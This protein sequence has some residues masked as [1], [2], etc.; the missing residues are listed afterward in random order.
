MH[1]VTCRVVSRG[2]PGENVPVVKH[3]SHAPQHEQFRCIQKGSIPFR[4][5]VSSNVPSNVQD[6]LVYGSSGLVRK[7]E[8]ALFPGVSSSSGTKS[9]RILYPCCCGIDPPSPFCIL[10][11]GVLH[12]YE[13]A[14]P[15][16][17]LNAKRAS[18]PLSRC[19]SSNS[20]DAQNKR[21]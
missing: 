17:C 3:P 7:P 16:N 18:P 4:F 13:K 12:M 2:R 9:V 1:T 19:L 20:A 14:V 15:S 5:E 8:I 10:E 6:D 11:H 21:H